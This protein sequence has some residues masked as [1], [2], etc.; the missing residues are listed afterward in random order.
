MLVRT[1]PGGPPQQ[2]V[3]QIL[4]ACLSTTTCPMG[5]MG[6]MVGACSPRHGL[7]RPAT[8]PSSAGNAYGPIVMVANNA[9]IMTGHFQIPT[10]PRIIRNPLIIPNP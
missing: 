4:D 7:L 10:E 1:V 6:D 8:A 3:V 5:S 2:L 9:I